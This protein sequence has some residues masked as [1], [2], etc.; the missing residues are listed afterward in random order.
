MAHV[1]EEIEI[2]ASPD[3]IW[4]L[5]GDPGRIADWLPALSSS[6]A[7]GSAR[8]CTM[9]NGAE[10]KERIL[11]HSDEQRSYSYEI[12]EAPVPLRCYTSRLSVHGHDGHTHVVWDA[13]FEPEDAEQEGELVEMFTQTYRE[14][15]E[16]LRERF[17]PGSAA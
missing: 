8:E 5:A 9:V 3:E 16:S 10:L 1:H 13:D 12:V 14:G 11:E 2:N 17:E 7:E 4:P 6:R 15:L